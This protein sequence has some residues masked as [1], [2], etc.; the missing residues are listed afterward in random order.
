MQHLAKSTMTRDDRQPACCGVIIH[1]KRHNVYIY[2]YIY[3][4]RLVWQR[5]GCPKSAKQICSNVMEG[6][7]E[8]WARWPSRGI[9]NFCLEVNTSD[10]GADISE[11]LLGG[12]RCQLLG[13]PWGPVGPW[14]AIA[15]WDLK[16]GHGCDTCRRNDLV[17]ICQNYVQCMAK[18]IILCIKFDRIYSNL[19]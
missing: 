15:P 13:R 18:S 17:R 3:G 9:R 19:I 10:L 7:C 12:E 4:S 1:A 6:V 14:D 8:R 16:K 5:S 11:V 2:I